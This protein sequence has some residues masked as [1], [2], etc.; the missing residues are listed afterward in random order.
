MGR[1]YDVIVVGARV[2]GAATA[3]LLAWRGLHVLAI[4]RSRFPS[5]TL[6]THQVQVPG[7]ALLARWGLLD[8]LQAMGTPATRI[9][10]FDVDGVRLSGAVP[11]AGEADAIYS[12]R[13][14]V[15]DALLV[16]RA[17]DAGAEVRE[18][19]TVDGLVGD[20]DRVA[21]IRG[22][23]RGGTAFTERSRLVVG[24]DGKHSTVA[25]GAG[26]RLR[27][28][29][30]AITF[31]SYSYW[32]D[33]D[34]DV[35]EVF[36]RPG[37]AVVAF[38][39]NDGLTVVLVCR[40]LAEFVAV[41]RDIEGGY[42]SGIAAT[43]ELGDR[44]RVGARVERIR[45]TP[46]LPHTLVQPIGPGWTLAGDAR[47]VMDP[48]SGQGISMA[49]H[50]AERLAT[51]VADGLG[52]RTPLEPALRGAWRS[53]EREARGIFDATA[54]LAR[55]ERLGSAQR[56]VLAAYAERPAA[57]ADLIAAFTGVL[58]W[59]GCSRPPEYSGRWR[60]KPYG[61]PWQTTAAI[62]PLGSDVV[63]YPHPS[64]R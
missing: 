24:A 7:A 17:R 20:A 4:D 46:D 38:P 30:R 39:T 11:A 35:G 56:R 9:V 32:S 42:L 8:D 5:D 19:C 3:M 64:T 43:G 58:P 59:N 45:T 52:G 51:A 61:E 53:R 50:D 22:R 44:I 36:L 6:S 33:A 21:G 13:R 54:G 41:R 63:R 31:A 62:E 15:L 10:R 27:R 48:V 25:A 40:P 23:A 12:P 49:L 37:L 28:G 57:T 2:A 14:T 16:A 60:R 26:A 1:P 29:G 55:L 47:M 34:V 18:A